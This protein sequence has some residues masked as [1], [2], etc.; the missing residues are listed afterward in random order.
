M[1]RGDVIQHH[2]KRPCTSAASNIQFYKVL[3]QGAENIL[4]AQANLFRTSR[5]GSKEKAMKVKAVIKNHY[6]F[7]IELHMCLH[8]APVKHSYCRN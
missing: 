6:P 4:E 2:R 3:E 8:I 1:P 5:K 7:T